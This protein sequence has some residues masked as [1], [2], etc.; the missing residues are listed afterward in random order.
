M[1]LTSMLQLP[2]FF[3]VLQAGR[4]IAVKPWSCNSRAIAGPVFHAGFAKQCQQPN[5]T[6]FDIAKQIVS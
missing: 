3:A 4:W 5:P 2:G 6:C 1:V